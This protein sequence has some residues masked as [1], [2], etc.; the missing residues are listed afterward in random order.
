MRYGI[1]VIVDVLAGD[2][3]GGL[4][5][6]HNDNTAS[7]AFKEILESNH[8]I[9]KHPAD[10]AMFYV[11]TMEVQAEPEIQVYVIEPQARLVVTGKAILTLIGGKS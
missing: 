1:Y 10:H 2:V 4:Q 6:H 3:A 8:P 11:G 7:R 5:L 9:A